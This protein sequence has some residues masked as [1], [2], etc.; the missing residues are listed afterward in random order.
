MKFCEKIIKL[1]KEQ[2]LSQEEF[3]MKINVSRQTISKWEA[4]Q[5]LPDYESLKQISEVFGISLDCLLD[6]NTDNL[7][8]PTKKNKG[9][10]ALNVKNMLKVTGII[11]A[12]IMVAYLVYSTYKF[13]M[14]LGH[15]NKVYAIPDYESYSEKIVTKSSDKNQGFGELES[16]HYLSVNENIYFFVGYDNLKMDL[17]QR[18]IGQVIFANSNTNQY[19]SLMYDEK[20]QKFV[21]DELFKDKSTEE[22][23]QILTDYG[24]VLDK[25][26]VRNNAKYVLAFD[27]SE[28]YENFRTPIKKLVIAALDFKTKVTKEYIEQRYYEDGYK[29]IDFRNNNVER[30][31]SSLQSTTLYEYELNIDEERFNEIH[32]I[33][34]LATCFGIPM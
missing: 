15:H 32:R 8:Q 21:E 22:I 2:G 31:S 5:A 3:G 7:K 19:Y 16:I 13:I 28:S 34:D 24:Y 10:K 9:I 17:G 26:G 18:T 12:S 14:L 27:E 20:L 1:R 4:E 25:A 11:L 30:W 23:K 6:D 33:E 29:K